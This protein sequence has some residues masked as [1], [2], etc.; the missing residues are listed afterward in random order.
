MTCG[1]SLAVFSQISNA[2]LDLKAILFSH[3]IASNLPFVVCGFLQIFNSD[4]APKIV[5]F[6]HKTCLRMRYCSPQLYRASFQ[7]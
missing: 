6:I 7:I 5:L 4:L 1:L 2:H 3:D